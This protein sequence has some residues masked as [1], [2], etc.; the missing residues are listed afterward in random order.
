MAIPEEMA[1]S[2]IISLL[3]K[4]GIGCDPVPLGDSDDPKRILLLMHC[5]H[6]GADARL[7]VQREPHVNP[8]GPVI[9]C[10]VGQDSQSMAL[11]QAITDVLTENGGWIPV[12]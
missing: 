10:S 6:G 8:D 4:H 3:Q 11:S 7:S 1:P 2:T 5:S 9:V 12:P